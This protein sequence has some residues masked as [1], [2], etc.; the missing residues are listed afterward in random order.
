VCAVFNTILKSAEKIFIHPIVGENAINR[1][2]RYLNCICTDLKGK[3]AG[4]NE[5]KNGRF[6]KKTI[7]GIRN[8]FNDHDRGVLEKRIDSVTSEKFAKLTELVLKLLCRH[9]QQRIDLVRSIESKHVVEGFVKKAFKVGCEKCDIDNI[10]DSFID[11]PL[12]M[13]ARHL[14]KIH[15]AN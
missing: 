14:W 9:F 8:S 5:V 4:E 13:F 1:I 10:A 12:E 3:I 6:Q 15:A 11:K 7:I 2:Y